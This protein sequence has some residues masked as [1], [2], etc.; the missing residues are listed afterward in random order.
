MASH[1]SPWTGQSERSHVNQS[2]ARVDAHAIHPRR[3]A[4]PPPVP[5]R[6]CPQPAG[7]RFGANSSSALEQQALM[8]RQRR[9][10]HARKVPAW[11]QQ[12][13][14]RS[15][16]RN[17]RPCWRSDDA[18]LAAVA[19]LRR[20]KESEIFFFQVGGRG[21]RHVSP[22]AGDV[23]VGLSARWAHVPVSGGYACLLFSDAHPPKVVCWVPRAD[24]EGAGVTSRQ[25]WCLGAAEERRWLTQGWFK[26]RSRQLFAVPCCPSIDPP[27]TERYRKQVQMSSQPGMIAHRRDPRRRSAGSHASQSY[28]AQ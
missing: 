19:D 13:W 21:A 16:R 24:G 2:L 1:A 28:K 7:C 20:G 11:W 25:P 10:E 26:A 15:V 9:I 14:R 22:R 3:R 17:W 5:C 6:A 12:A 4:Q 23:S 8:R 18:P 27:L